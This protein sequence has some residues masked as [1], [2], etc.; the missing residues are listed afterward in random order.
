[1][2]ALLASL[3]NFQTTQEAQQHP[4][5]APKRKTARADS[6]TL[7]FPGPER[8]EASPAVREEWALVQRAICGDSRAKE[9]IFI[10]H[11]TI[12]YRIALSI[13]RNREDAE[14]AVQDALWRAYAKLRSFQG[15]S[16]FSTWLNRIVIN[17]ALMIRRRRNARPE[18]SLQALLDGWPERLQHQIV[19]AGPNP[20]DICRIAEIH[21]IVAEHIRQLPPRLREALQL[22]DLDGLSTEDSS[23]VLGIRQGAFKSRVARARQ[24]LANGLQQSFRTPTSRLPRVAAQIPSSEIVRS[25]R[26][27]INPPILRSAACE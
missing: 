13:L 21:D 19:D 26:S 24:R 10:P 15:R 16:T 8:T 27:Q 5:D 1:M 2:S 25:S 18:A 3:P 20:E 4:V 11:T 7:R 9:Q 12:L 14:D 23:H 17:S 6:R 22:C